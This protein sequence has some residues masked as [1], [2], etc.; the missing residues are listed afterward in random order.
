MAPLYA[1]LVGF[2]LAG[3]QVSLFMALQVRCTAA[4]PSFL[5]TTAGWLVGSLAGLWLPRRG[6]PLA[7]SLAC[8]APYLLL[9]WLERASF[10]PDLLPFFT[11]LV[12]LT[13]L[14]AG[15]F[16]RS[17]LPAF[18]SP[19]LLFFW[20]NNGFL[21]GLG[22]S[23]LAILLWGIRVAWLWP[24]GAILLIALGLT[25]KGPGSLL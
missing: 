21:L 8:L 12:A 2:W 4:F 3:L 11:L 5:A 22:A 20:E 6:A 24:V 13:G 14:Y 7:L 15:S 19:G 16:F 23:S 25:R 9:G 18:S 10:R 1:F 17:Q